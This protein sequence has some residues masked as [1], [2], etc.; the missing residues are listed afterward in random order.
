MWTLR[1]V[2]CDAYRPYV[3]VDDDLAVVAEIPGRVRIARSMSPWAAGIFRI[4]HVGRS[5]L[6]I[7]GIGGEAARDN[8]AI[9]SQERGLV[10]GGVCLPDDAELADLLAIARRPTVGV[11]ILDLR[12]WAESP[13]VEIVMVDLSMRPVELD[14]RAVADLR[15]RLSATNRRA[16]VDP[17][18][19]PGPQRA[20]AEPLAEAAL[21]GDEP[22]LRGLLVRLV[23]SGPGTTPAGDDVIVGV[24]A[25]LSATYVDA[26]ARLARHL[27]ALLART[28]SASRHD[29]I[30]AIDGCYAEQVHRI[31]TALADLRLARAT[32]EH[33]Q[34]WGATSGL[35]HVAGAVGAATSV[36]RG[37]PPNASLFA[38][39]LLSPYD[40]RRSA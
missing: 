16:V 31:V 26:H 21:A 3:T 9:T 30:A 2:M 6:I 32:V 19:D 25:T 29:L 14:A 37:R 4:V 7:A 8:V 12:R 1:L 10:P 35:D 33:A 18:M 23:G 24:L 15:A 20:L 22:T 38:L 11:G 17:L 13:P 40:L 39:R 36:L 34:T 5:S 28:T 27:P